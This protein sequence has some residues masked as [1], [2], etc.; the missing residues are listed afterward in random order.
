MLRIN[1]TSTPVAVLRSD[2]HG[3]LNIIRSLGRLGVPVYNV[4]P[5]PSAPAF[6]SRYCQGMFLWDIEHQPTD[7]SLNYLCNVRRK[8]ARPCILIPTTDRTAQFVADHSKTLAEDF[9][10]PKQPDGLVHSLASKQ[11]MYHLA[12]RHNIP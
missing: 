9:I 4:D 8:I 10:F 5:N 7:E 3:G 1:D 2:S 11:E 12:L 6:W